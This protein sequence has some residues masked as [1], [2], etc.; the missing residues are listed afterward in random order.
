[1]AGARKFQ[2]DQISRDDLM[3]ANRET[4]EVTGIPYMTDAQHDRAMAIL[5][6]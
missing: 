4:A 5:Q 3:A 2:V 6:K 1:M